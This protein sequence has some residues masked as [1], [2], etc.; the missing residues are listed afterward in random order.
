[1]KPTRGTIL[2]VAWAVLVAG[3]V[4]VFD[5]I[6]AGRGFEA[7]DAETY[8]AAGERLNAGHA[9]YAL[10][11][12]DRPILTNPAFYTYPLL[13]PPPIAVLWRALAALPAGWGIGLWWLA[14]I[15]SVVATLGMVFRRLPVLAG[16]SVLLFAPFVAWELESGNVDGLFFAGIAATWLLALRRRDVAA[17]AL[18]GVMAGIKLWPV[19]LLLWFVGQS[20]WRAVAGATIAL[21][22]VGLLSVAGAG[23]PAHFEYLGIARETAASPLS[24]PGMLQ[25]AGLNLPWAN[26]LV[27]VLGAALVLVLRDRV[28]LTFA[29]AIPTMILGSPVVN[30][31]TYALMLIGLVPFVWPA[32]ARVDGLERRPARNHGTIGS[33]SAVDEG[34]TI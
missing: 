25:A 18:V 12:G 7:F 29:V 31:N 14:C 3:V 9:L 34:L 2:L 4:F 28:E 26:Y 1:M 6:I 23:L 22:V 21:L 5:R 27:L 20:R 19:V 11:P 8:L 30:I 10:A 33:A 32:N 13:S 24:L 17:G 16:L 15:G